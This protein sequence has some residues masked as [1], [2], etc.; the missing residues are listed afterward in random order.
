MMSLLLIDEMDRTSSPAHS[1]SKNEEKTILLIQKEEPPS[2]HSRGENSKG[3]YRSSST[4]SDLF[5]VSL[6]SCD[7]IQFSDLFEAEIYL[8]QRPEWKA[9]GLLG[10]RVIIEGFDFDEAMQFVKRYNSL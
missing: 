9:R 5:L 6:L 2:Q 7:M 3:H 1:T 4:P 10:F 8:S